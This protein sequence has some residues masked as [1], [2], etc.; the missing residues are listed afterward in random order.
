MLHFVVPTI[1]F[2]PRLALQFTIYLGEL[3]RPTTKLDP[4]EGLARETVHLSKRRFFGNFCGGR[5][6]RRG[7]EDTRC[8]S[9]RIRRRPPLLRL[10]LSS[11]NDDRW[12]R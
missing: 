6:A 12:R 1:G 5:S 3:L 10:A 2:F 11:W 4:V 7:G 8:D 9:T